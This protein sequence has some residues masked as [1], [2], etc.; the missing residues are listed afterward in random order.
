MFRPTTF[1]PPTATTARNS[2]KKLLVQCLLK[3]DAWRPKHVQDNYT[4]KCLWKWKCIKLVTQLWYTYY[5]VFPLSICIPNR[6]IISIRI[7]HHSAILP[8]QKSARRILHRYDLPY[9]LLG[10]VCYCARPTLMDPL[11]RP[12]IRHTNFD[13]HWNV[14]DSGKPKYLGEKTIQVPSG[15][16][17]I[18]H[19]L[20]WNS[21]Q[22][23]AVKSC[24][25][26]H[27]DLYSHCHL[28]S[29]L[30]T[31]CP[32]Y[33]TGTPLPSI[34]Q[35]YIFFQQIYV[36]NFLNMLHILRIS[37]FKMLFIS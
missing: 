21:A 9:S 22:A 34:T 14:T 31:V 13:H 1:N 18:P 19:A 11:F 23:F 4:I 33:R 25:P 16:L 36:L 26:C 6:N 7:S 28:T 2:H 27:L 17:K 8:P 24:Q 29:P 5:F 32:I 30:G 3:M 10:S 37:L 20:T 15:P 35:F 12:R